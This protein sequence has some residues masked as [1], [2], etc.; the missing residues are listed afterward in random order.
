VP[1]TVGQYAVLSTLTPR[2][3]SPFGA[4]VGD[5]LV[6]VPARHTVETVVLGGLHHLDLLNHPRVYRRLAGWLAAPGA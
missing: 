2:P 1:S 3:T 6:P 5:G 4:R